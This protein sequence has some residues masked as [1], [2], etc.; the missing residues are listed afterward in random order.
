MPKLLWWILLVLAA[1][2]ILTAIG[3]VY[4]NEVRSEGFFTLYQGRNY[5]EYGFPW[6]FWRCYEGES[7]GLVAGRLLANLL[8]WGGGA[9][10]VILVIGILTRR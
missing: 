8:F 10:L 7:C 3:L 2:V 9:S 5:V 1:A 4:V 6:G